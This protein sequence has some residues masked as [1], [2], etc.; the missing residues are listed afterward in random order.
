MQIPGFHFAHSPNKMQTYYTQFRYYVCSI[1]LL[2]VW[3]VLYFLVKANHFHVIIFNLNFTEKI[4]TK[5]PGGKGCT[6]DIAGLDNCL[7]SLYLTGRYFVVHLIE[8]KCAR[9]VGL[10]RKISSGA[11]LK[12]FLCK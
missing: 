11:L 9:F 5:C 6:F 2:F 10:P 12:S 1:A 8:M 3:N 4:T 7:F